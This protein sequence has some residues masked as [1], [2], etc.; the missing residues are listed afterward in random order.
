[1]GLQLGDV[2]QR[3]FGLDVLVPQLLHLLL[4]AAVLGLGVHEPGEIAVDVAE[5]PRDALGG[6]L[7][8]VEDG[9]ARALRA[10]EGAATRLAERH[11][12]EHEREQHEHPQQDPPP[13]GVT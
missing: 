9:R 7:E 13:K 1:L 6:D 10:V 8:R 11:R 3:G 2:L 4:Q 12:D 5:R